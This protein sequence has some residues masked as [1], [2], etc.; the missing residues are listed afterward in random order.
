MPWTTAKSFEAAALTSAEPRPLRLKAR[1][2]TAESA[3]SEAIVI[4][5]TVVIGIAAL[6]STWR[7]MTRC[8]GQ[9]AADRRLHVL[10]PHLLA[11]ADARHAR[12][13]R[14]RRQRQRDRGERQVPEPVDASGSRPERREPA[15]LH[16]EDTLISTIAATNDGIAAN[17]VVPAITVVSTAPR[18]SPARIPEPIPNSRIRIEAYA[19]SSNVT[20][21]RSPIR[22]LTLSRSAI[23]EPR[24]P[25]SADV[26]QC[27]YC[28]EQRLVEVVA[29]P[30]HR[31]CLRRQGSAAGEH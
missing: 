12:D 23:D 19:T 29:R 27:Q 16:R 5:V 21:A 6:R 31:Q 11:H 28:A 22:V 10:S 3:I 1:S 14:Q 25:C 26:S 7:R 8:R 4:P 20:P 9:P 18:R 24:S 17:T 15:E 2:T 13:D 30:Q